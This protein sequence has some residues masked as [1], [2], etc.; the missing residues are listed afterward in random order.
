MNG[1]KNHS[2]PRTVKAKENE[3]INLAIDEAER[4]IRAG[5]ASSQIIT[6][7]LRLGSVKERLEEEILEEKKK[8]LKAQTESIESTKRME[9][10]YTEAIRAM[11]RYSPEEEDEEDEDCFYEDV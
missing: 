3:M 8:L 4:R 1:K 2:K 10:L 5:N 6:H 9:K 7:Y 11:K